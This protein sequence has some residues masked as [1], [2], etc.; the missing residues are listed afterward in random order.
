MAHRLLEQGM[1]PAVIRSAFSWLHS[2]HWPLR[3]GFAAL[4]L[5]GCDGQRIQP[6]QLVIN[7]LMSNNEGA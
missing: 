4:L 7:E 1:I 2:A 5:L 6:G 3:T